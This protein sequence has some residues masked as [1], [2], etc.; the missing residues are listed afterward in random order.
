[1]SLVM[2]TLKWYQLDHQVLSSFPFATSIFIGS[3]LSSKTRCCSRGGGF[4]SLERILRECSTILS[5]PVLFL[6]LFFKVEISSRTLIPLLRPGPVHSGSASWDDCGRM[7]PDKLRV[8]SFHDRFQ[9][10][11]WTAALSAHSDFVGSRVY[12]CLGVTGHLHFWQ[13][14]RGL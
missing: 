6:L 3:R 14:D 11:A 5:P 8:S 4:S 12:A 1:M 7:F 9:H 13:N 10:N 2:S